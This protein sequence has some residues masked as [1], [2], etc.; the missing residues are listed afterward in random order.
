MKKIQAISSGF[1]QY[2]GLTKCGSESLSDISLLQ[3]KKANCEQWA[4]PGFRF[5][6][7]YVTMNELSTAN[8]LI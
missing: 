2:Q 3:N 5:D 8:G 6:K 1:H 7:G 4:D